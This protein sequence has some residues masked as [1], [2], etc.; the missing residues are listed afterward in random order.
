MFHRTIRRNNEW[1]GRLKKESIISGEFEFLFCTDARVMIFRQSRTKKKVFANRYYYEGSHGIVS[2]LLSSAHLFN[3]P[4]PNKQIGSHSLE[5]EKY[6]YWS[7]AIFLSSS[8]SA[9]FLLLLLLLYT[10]DLVCLHYALALS[11]SVFLSPSRFLY[12]KREHT[13]DLLLLLFDMHFYKRRRKRKKPRTTRMHR[14]SF[15]FFFF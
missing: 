7:R 4:S 6:S 15:S 11:V 14:F 13:S 10:F 5:K 12:Y 3:L 1:V 9:F 2:P 8:Y